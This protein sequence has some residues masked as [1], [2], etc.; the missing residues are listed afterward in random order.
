MSYNGSGTFNINTAGQ[1]VVTGTTITSTAFNLLTADLATGLSTAITKDGQ[2]TT[3]ALIPFAVGA[4]FSATTSVA[5]GVAFALDG[6]NNT[7]FA[8]ISADVIQCV[9][10]GTEAWRTTSAHYFKASNSGT[11]N[12]ATGTYHELYQDVDTGQNVCW[13]VNAAATATNQYGPVTKLAGDPNDATRYFLTSIGNATERATIRSNGGLANFTANDVN[14]SDLRT[15]SV[16][17]IYDD[18]LLDDLEN[19]FLAI[20]RGR[21]KYFDQTHDDWNYGKSAQSVAAVMPELTDVWNPTKIEKVGT[22]MVVDNG[23]EKEIDVFAILATAPEEQLLA[24]HSYDISQIGEAILARLV[25]RVRTLEA[26]AG[27]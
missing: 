27:I 24:E 22:E 18:A 1:P 21:F 17:E 2:T 4:S 26:K 8:E 23:A 20:D 7:Y 6:G 15:K 16:F 11:Y 10:G 14:L 19:K 3:T 13:F 5:S 25:Q 9:T 12:A